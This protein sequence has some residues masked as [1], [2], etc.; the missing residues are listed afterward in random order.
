MSIS[1]LASI[2]RSPRGMRN[3]L[4]PSQA[5]EA[6]TSEHLNRGNTPGR[7]ELRYDP[8]ISSSALPSPSVISRIASAFSSVVSNSGLAV[9]FS[10][11]PSSGIGRL[12][13]FPSPLRDSV[14]FG[15]RAS[16]M[17]AFLERPR[18]ERRFRDACGIPATRLAEKSGHSGPP[19]M[20]QRKNPL[21]SP[22]GAFQQP[23]ERQEEKLAIQLKAW[24]E[25]SQRGRWNY[26]HCALVAMSG[27]RRLFGRNDNRERN[28]E[29]LSIA[30]QQRDEENKAAPNDFAANIKKLNRALDAMCFAAIDFGLS[31]NH[32]KRK[33]GAAERMIYLAT[34]I[35]E[36][37]RLLKGTGHRYQ[38]L[39]DGPNFTRMP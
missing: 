16:R 21:I 30:L 38:Y 14:S 1:G 10:N 35:A 22:G 25:K 34:E 24:W 2:R 5:I 4:F 26:R 29:E 23:N 6:W 36:L 37:G 27:F 12:K 7:H 19:A 20:G 32:F 13:L 9:A 31:T 33:E 11:A 15:G 3:G 28:H 39:E 18:H 8:T 17:C